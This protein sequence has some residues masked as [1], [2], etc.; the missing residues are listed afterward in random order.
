MR[1][2]Q[3]YISCQVYRILDEF[4]GCDNWLQK[5]TKNETMETEVTDR[6][7]DTAWLDILKAVF[8]YKIY[9]TRVT[10]TTNS[11]I[12]IRYKFSLLFFVF[13]RFT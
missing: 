5:E 9:T 7:T 11:L 1:V 4:Y 10:V 3:N 13:F 8:Y 2:C 12:V 6:H